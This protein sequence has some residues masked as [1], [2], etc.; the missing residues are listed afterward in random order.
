MIGRSRERGAASVKAERDDVKLHGRVH[1]AVQ[2]LEQ[3]SGV[4]PEHGRHELQVVSRR[5]LRVRR[6]YV[7]QL[8]DQRVKMHVVFRRKQGGRP[9][10]PTV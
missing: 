8:R 9:E 2:F 4:L 10:G 5:L 6:Q 3:M 1:G 7:P